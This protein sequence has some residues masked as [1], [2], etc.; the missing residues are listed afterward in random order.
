MS[1]TETPQGSGSDDRYDEAR[2]HVRRLREFYASLGAFVVVN[3]M[4]FLINLLTR[5]PGE[6]ADGWWFYWVT[7][8]WGIGI[9]FQAIGVYGDRWGKDWEDRK[10]QQYMDGR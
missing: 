7:I 9:L 8:F 3:L 5:T 2:K 4:L 10:I 6:G 1:E